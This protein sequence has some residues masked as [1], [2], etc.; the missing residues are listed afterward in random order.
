L[1]LLLHGG[2]P[3]DRR[4]ARGL[5]GVG[6]AFLGVLTRHPRSVALHDIL[7]PGAV[8]NAILAI[9]R[10]NGLARTDW[11]VADQTFALHGLIGGIAMSLIGPAPLPVAADDP[12]GVLGAAVTA[13]LGPERGNQK[14][15]RGA[16]DEVIEFLRQR[17]VAALRLIDPTQP[18][19]GT[20]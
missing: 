13:L 15:V 11:D 8:L 20:R 3:D 5:A 19:G 12:L 9:W 1:G 6:R 4:Y 16:A 2:F 17:R 10:G 7:G 14:Q 18:Q